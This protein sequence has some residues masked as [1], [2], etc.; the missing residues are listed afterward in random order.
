MKKTAKWM[1]SYRRL[2]PAA[3]CANLF[4]LRFSMRLP[5]DATAVAEFPANFLP[6][7]IEDMAKAATPEGFTFIGVEKIKDY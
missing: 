3:G 6:I 4:G 5:S 7:S 1:A 2:E